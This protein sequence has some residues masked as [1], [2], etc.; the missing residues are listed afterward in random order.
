MA[1]FSL[2]IDDTDV[3]R[4]FDSVCGNYNWSAQISNPDFEEDAIDAEGNSIPELID[5]P[6]SQGDFTHRMV[7]QFLS[8]H[9]GAWELKEVKRLAAESVDVSVNIGNPEV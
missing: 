1:V 8:D 5:N 4:V 3:Q 9:V 6:E 7:R 2:E